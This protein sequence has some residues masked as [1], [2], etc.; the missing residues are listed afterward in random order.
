MAMASLPGKHQKANSKASSSTASSRNGWEGVSFIELT[1]WPKHC[2]E[3][4]KRK[5]IFDNVSS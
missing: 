2:N 5:L 4:S 3:R 1:Q